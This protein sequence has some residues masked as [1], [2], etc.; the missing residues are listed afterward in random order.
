MI[1]N[2]LHRFLVK[3]GQQAPAAAT[4]TSPAQVQQQDVRQLAGVN[5]IVF[6]PRSWQFINLFVNQLNIA[7]F[8]L[9]KN[10]KFGSGNSLNFQTVVRNPSIATSFTGSLK[11]LFDLSLQLWRLLKDQRATPYSI[12]EATNIANQLKV[13]INTLDFPEASAGTVKPNLINILNNWL[14]I[15]K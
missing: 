2:Y 12:A 6:G 3:L 15:L 5:Q 14:A 7:L 8:T 9:G 10:Q 4:T 1:D 13:Q 11:H